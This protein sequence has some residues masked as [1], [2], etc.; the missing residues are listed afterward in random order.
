MVR[1]ESARTT[2]KN[3]SV[4]YDFVELDKNQLQ[5]ELLDEKKTKEARL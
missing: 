5:Q 1:I 2:S 4:H 3:I